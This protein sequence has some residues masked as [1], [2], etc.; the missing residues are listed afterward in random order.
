VNAIN[1]PI[2]AHLDGRWFTLDDVAG[3]FRLEDRGDGRR[4]YHEPLPTARRGAGYRRYARFFGSGWVVDV[5]HD[6][7]LPEIARRTGYA[8]KEAQ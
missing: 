6:G 3:R 5:T 1:A 4:L 8:A 7:R 2:L